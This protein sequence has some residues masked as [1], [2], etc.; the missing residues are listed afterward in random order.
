V[1]HSAPRRGPRSRQPSRWRWQRQLPYAIV[2]CGLALALVRIQQSGRNV[3]GGTLAVAGVLLAAALVRLALPERRAGM[4]VS[5]ARLA[6]VAA[7]AAFGV[8]LLV[9][10]LVLPPQ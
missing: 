3:R 2:V 6:D 7:L 10:G 4:L 9:A 5:R 8:G 1:R